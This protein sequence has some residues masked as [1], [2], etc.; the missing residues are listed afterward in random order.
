MLRPSYPA[1][2]HVRGVPAN[3][4]HDSYVIEKREWVNGKLQQATTED[5]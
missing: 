2:S 4:N 5:I 1:L 3:T